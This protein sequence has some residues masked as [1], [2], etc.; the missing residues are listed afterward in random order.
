MRVSFKRNER[1]GFVLLWLATLLLLLVAASE[2]SGVQAQVPAT[3]ETPGAFNGNNLTPIAPTYN[4]AGGNLSYMRFFNINSGAASTFVVTVVGAPSGNAYGNPASFVVPS[5]AS[6]Q[7][8]L[9][10]ILSAAGAGPLAGG[11]TGYTLYVRNPDGFSAFQHVIFNSLNGFFEN[12]TI[13]Q[14]YAGAQH[15][16]VIPVVANMHTSRIAQ[17]PSEITVHN[18]TTAARAYTASVFDSV[19][20]AALG[21]VTF[22]VAANDTARLSTAAIEQQLNFTPSPTQFHMNVKLGD[23][24]STLDLTALIGHSVLNNAFNGTLLNLT[25]LCRVKG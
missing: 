11:D 23:A 8:S 15:V 6:H 13:C 4:G 22:N 24:A 9:T 2:L 7:R 5:N 20:G 19:T 16:R 1:A 14:F 10:E 3:Q 25:T 12:A 21:N 17:Y 18:Y